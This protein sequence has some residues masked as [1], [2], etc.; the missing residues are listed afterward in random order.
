MSTSVNPVG[1]PTKEPHSNTTPPTLNTHPTTQPPPTT[2]TSLYTAL[3]LPDTAPNCIRL[4]YN[5][6][7]ALPTEEPATLNTILTNYFKLQ[8]T[9]LGIMETK[10]NWARIDDTSKPLRQAANALQQN[11]TRLSTASCREQ[12]TSQSLKQPG[13][14]AQ[15]TLNT[16]VSL[17]RATGA[18]KIERWTWQEYRLDGVK[19]LVVITA[20][21]VGNQPPRSSTMTT[22][23]HQQY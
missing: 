5:N 1:T 6:R 4:I 11:K 2:I 3:P 9:I 17:V 22:A 7:N 12:H 23:W 20:Y 16:I 21:R 18:D 15:I 10:R 8:P 14:V 13:G 19:T